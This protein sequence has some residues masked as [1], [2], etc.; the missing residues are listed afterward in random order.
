MIKKS[1]ITLIGMP[2]AGKSTVGIILAKM[3]NLGFLDTDIL[4]QINQQ[5]TLQQIVDES[6]HMRLRQIEEMEICKVNI[7]N[8]VIA[9][10]GSAAYSG[11]AMLHLAKNSTIIFLEVDYDELLKRIKNFESRGIA[12]SKNQTFRELF[13]ERQALY[14]RYADIVIDCTNLNQE[15]TAEEIKLKIKTLNNY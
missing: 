4:I 15:E 9:T 2:G 6:G 13:D 1:N 7:D 10:G 8:H 11:K 14:N 12:K 3:M 5:K